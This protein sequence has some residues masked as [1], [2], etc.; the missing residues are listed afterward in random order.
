MSCCGTVSQTSFTGRQ[1]ER[2]VI[3]GEAFRVRVKITEA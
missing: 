3:A 1:A 2:A